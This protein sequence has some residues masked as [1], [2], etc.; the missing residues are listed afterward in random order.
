M[1]HPF[2]EVYRIRQYLQ[3][4][5]F[6]YFHFKKGYKNKITYCGSKIKYSAETLASFDYKED[7]EISYFAHS[8]KCEDIM[9]WRTDFKNNVLSPLKF[10]SLINKSDTNL[11][12][13]LKYAFEPS[14]M[15]HLPSLAAKAIASNKKEYA[16]LIYIHITGWMEQNPYL[17]SSNWRDGIEVGIR[18]T[19]VIYC[20]NILK[21]NKDFI[22]DDM[23]E[24]INEMTALHHHFLINHLSLYSSANNH[25]LAE[26]FGI[27]AILLNFKMKNWE[28]QFNKYLSLF[29]N[30]IKKQVNTDGFSKEQSTCY[31]I[32]V[33]NI[34]F[35]IVSILQSHNYEIPEDIKLRIER[36]ISFL[37][38]LEINND[39]Y[40]NIGDNDDSEI[41]YPALATNYNKYKSLFNGAG[42]FIGS[43]TPANYQ[44]DLKNY[45]IWGEEGF[46]KYQ[47]LGRSVTVSQDKKNTIFKESGYFIFQNGKSKLFF[48]IGPLGMPPL[49]AHGHSD[50]LHFCLAYKG[51]PFIVDNGT[52]Q[53]NYKYQK[54]RNYFRG[55]SA[56]NT[57]SIDNLNHAEIKGSMLWNKLPRNQLIGYSLDDKNA[58]CEAS[59]NGFV[60]QGVDVIHRRKILYDGNYH[61]YDYLAGSGEHS[62]RYFLN[63]SPLLLQ[64]RFIDE[65][66]LLLEADGG[67]KVFIENNLFRY[68]KLYYGDENIPLGWYSDRFDKK[69]ASYCLLLELKHPQITEIYSKIVFE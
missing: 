42:I 51:I 61:I 2:E 64:V 63:F 34:V 3:L 30:E 5:V 47:L 29:F 31:N 24:K 66:T 11:I 25:L 67:E 60:N 53:Y 7:N 19:N 55:I 45:I 38:N 43:N 36:M 57:I 48:D 8:M 41:I 33:L 1:E 10:S 9:S 40:L 59:H 49:A 56:H 65:N 39:T 52:F 27:L 22:I 62:I 15:Q 14:R 68:A 20:Y 44:F 50:L 13:E 32:D 54:W 23:D 18:I 46:R 16:E 4:Y 12:G 26:L 28:K 6:D 17:S 69:N 21:L 58:Y 37:S 35:V